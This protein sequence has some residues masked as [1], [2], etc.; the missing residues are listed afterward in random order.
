MA[1]ISLLAVDLGAASGRL[2]RGSFDGKKI[3]LS[4]IY[5]FSNESIELDGSLYWDILYL[6][7]EIKTG[8]KK[9]G[10]SIESIAVDSWGADFCMFDEN[11]KLTGNSYSYRDKRTEFMLDDIFSHIPKN[12]LF[13][14]SA[15]QP[16]QI[17]TLCQLYSMV[18][19][20]DPQLKTTKTILPIANAFSFFLSGKKVFD[21]TNASGTMFFD[22]KKKTWSDYILYKLGIDR[23]ILPEVSKDL[24]DLGMIKNALADDLG[25]K[26]CKVI[27]TG[28]H[29]TALA[30]MSICS[31]E[32]KYLYISCGTW[33]VVGVKL[34]A[35]VTDE[36]AFDAGLTNFGTPDGGYTL[37]RIITGLWIIQECRR[38]WGEKNL[39]YSYEKMSEMINNEKE[40]MSVIDVSDPIFMSP[41]D[42]PDKI[43]DHCIKTNQEPPKNPGQTAKSVYAGLAQKY[44]ETVEMIEDVVDKKFDTLYLIGGGSLDPVFCEFVA[45]ICKRTVKAGPAE[46]TALGNI[47]MQLKV[48][49]EIKNFDE[50]KKILLNTVNPNIY[51]PKEQ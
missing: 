16:S 36:K 48:S 44:K 9:A 50:T 28:G 27:S 24:W 26:N 12:E 18:K 10:T 1:K 34:Q 2:I 4:E 23:S 42:M 43:S 21:F 51:I 13:N 19:N 20:N 41:G 47:L 40:F 35:P 11:D 6:W 32:K 17:S 25:S 14:I 33:S 31:D 30:V 5:R 3:G 29:D 22:H 46:A 15:N 7:K 8:I 49:G 39:L 45:N 38:F 37:C